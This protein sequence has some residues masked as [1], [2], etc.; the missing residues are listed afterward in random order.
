MFK[1]W[2]CQMILLKYNSSVFFIQFMIEYQL[3][4]GLHDYQ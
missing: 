2:L 4:N 1:A 3:V